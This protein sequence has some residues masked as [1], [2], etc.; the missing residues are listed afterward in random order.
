MNRQADLSVT[1]LL[2]AERNAVRE[3]REPSERVKQLDNDAAAALSP[4]IIMRNPTKGELKG[5]HSINFKSN[6]YKE[7]TFSPYFIGKIKGQKACMELERCPLC[8]DINA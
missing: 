2:G 3:H 5:L 8:Q 7:N 4:D 6:S 1:Q